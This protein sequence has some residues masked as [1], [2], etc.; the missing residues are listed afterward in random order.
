[1]ANK[2][3]YPSPHGDEMQQGRRMKAAKTYM[4][5]SPHGDEMQRGVRRMKTKTAMYPSPHG[6]E[7]QREVSPAF[8]GDGHVSV[9]AWG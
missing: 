8:A 2:Q 9:P 4:Y 1:M 3:K 5:P 6:D 7:M